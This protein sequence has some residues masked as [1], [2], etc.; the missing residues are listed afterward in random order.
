[1]ASVFTRIINGEIPS[2]KVAE[3]EYNF[4]F[5]DINPLKK[6]HVLVVPKKEV[7]Y[8]YD[9]PENEYLHLSNFTRKVAIAIKTAIPCK[10][11][12]EVVL[13]FEVPHAHIHLIPINNEGEIN[14]SNS[15][16]QLSKEEMIEI[17]SSIAAKFN[18]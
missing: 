10:R 3:D 6:G 18:P 17:A 4:A 5:L 8:L 16:L 12:G 11:I 7:D 14:F 9:L 2:Y 15:K 13:G 1:M